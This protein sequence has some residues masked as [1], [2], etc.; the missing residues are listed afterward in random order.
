MEEIIRVRKIKH[1][2]LKNYYVSRNGQIFNSEF[3]EKNKT[4]ING[5]LTIKKN[6]NETF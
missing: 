3:I 4:L 2:E 1:S 6:K 5:Y